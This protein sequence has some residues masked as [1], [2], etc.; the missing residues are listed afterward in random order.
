MWVEKGFLITPK[1]SERALEGAESWFAMYLL[2]VHK[3]PLVDLTKDKPKAKTTVGTSPDGQM[4]RVDTSG[5]LRGVISMCELLSGECLRTQLG[6]SYMKDPF[7][8]EACQNKA[9]AVGSGSFTG[10]EVGSGGPEKVSWRMSPRGNCADRCSSALI[11]WDQKAP[12]VSQS[13]TIQASPL[14]L[15]SLTSLPLCSDGVG[16]LGERLHR[17]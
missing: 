12:V 17:S 5:A 9:K 16:T 14:F 11:H 7:L 6:G 3:T 15:F 4:R 13:R 10:Q 1:S 8:G 2:G